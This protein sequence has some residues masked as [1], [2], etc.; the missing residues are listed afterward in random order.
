MK[1]WQY[2]DD[3]VLSN[4][5]EMI[6]NRNLLKIKLKNKPIKPKLLNDHIKELMGK[7][8]ITKAEAQYF[9]FVDSISNQAYQS[10]LQTIKILQKSGKVVDIAKA[11]DQFNIKAL[12]K[13]VTKHYICYPKA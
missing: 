7:H 5:C 12:S 13:P 10:K 11:S 9:V 2:H 1:E 4:L 8:N 6:I 3:F